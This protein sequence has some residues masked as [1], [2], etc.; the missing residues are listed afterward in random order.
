MTTGPGSGF[1]I[2]GAQAG[3]MSGHSVS[4]AG[5]VN[6]DGLADII[7]GSIYGVYSTRGAVGIAYIIFGRTAFSDIDLSTWA[8]GPTQGFRVVGAIVSEQFSVAVAGAGDINGD[9]FDDVIIGANYGSY[10]T[11]G[12]V[13]TACVVFGRA[14]PPALVDLATWAPTTSDGFRIFGVA[15]GDETGRALRAAGN[16]NGDGI[17]DV[18]LG[19][20]G[21]NPPGRTDAGTA[22]VIF[23]RATFPASIDLASW[24]TDTMN[25]FR[26]LGAAAG[27]GFGTHVSGAGDVNG[28]GTDDFIVGAHLFDS[29]GG[30]DAGAIYVIFGRVVAANAG[31]AFTEL[32]MSTFT[33]GATL[34]FRLLGA[35][36]SALSGWCVS[37]AGDVNG[38]GYSDI[39][40]GAFGFDAPGKV[41]AG[42]VYVIYGHNV[43]LPYQDIDLRYFVT[44]SVTG[45]R[46]VGAAAGDGLGYYVRSAGD[47]NNDGLADVMVSA[48]YADQPGQ[49]DAGT[50]YII[51]GVPNSPT[52]QP[53]S[54]PSRQP[55]RQPTRQPTGQPTRCP[56]RQPSSQPSAQPTDQPTS[57]PTRQPYGN[58]SSQ[59]SRQPT[60]CPTVQ[61]SAQPTARPSRQPSTQPTGIPTAQPS[62]Q[63]TSQPTIQPSSRPSK[64]PSSQPTV[65][66][67]SQPTA[68]PSVQPTAQPSH[69][70]TAEPSS[71]PT[72]TP[73][74]QPTSRPTP[75]PTAQPSAQPSA[76]PSVQP[77]SMPSCQPSSQ[78]SRQPSGE[79]TGQPTSTPTVQPSSQPTSCPSSVPSTQ[80]SN[81][82]SGQPSPEPSAQPSERPSSQP[83]AQPSSQPSRLPSAQP[84][85][86]P[87]A[88]PSGQPTVVP[89]VVPS[90]QPS[91]VP[92]TQP[93][94]IPSSQPSAQ[95]TLQP[96][97]Q[98]SAI[99][100]AAPS[101]QPMSCPTAQPSTQP[102][103]RPSAQPTS[104]PSRQPSAQPTSQ[105]TAAPSATNVEF[106][107]PVSRSKVASAFAL[108]AQMWVCS[109]A[110]DTTSAQCKTIATV[111]GAVEQ[112]Y[113]FPW[114]KTNYVFAQSASNSAYLSG[115]VRNSNITGGTS[116]SSAVAVC[117]AH[118]VHLSCTVKSFADTDIVAAS[119]NSF[120]QKAVYIGTYAS[121]PT[122]LVVDSTDAV[123]SFMYSA[124]Y[125]RAITLATV[126]HVPN[127]IGSFVAGPCVSNTAA[128]Q[129]MIF[130]GWLRSDTGTLSAAYVTTTSGMILNTAGLVN[131]M[132]VETNG[133]DS[134]IVGGLQLSDGVGMCGYMFRINTLFRDVKYGM[135]YTVTREGST[136]R[137]LL[138]SVEEASSTI[139]SVVWRDN[140]LFAVLQSTSVNTTSAA[141]L[142]LN[143]VTGAVVQQVSLYAPNASLICVSIQSTP[144]TVIITCNIYENDAHVRSVVIAADL[145]LTFSALPPGVHRGNDTYRAENVE[146]RATQ[147]SVT[148]APATLAVSNYQFDTSNQQPLPLSTAA[149]TSATPSARPSSQPTSRP[150]GQ[151]SSSPTSTPSMSP[152]PT[153]HPSTSGP[154]GTHKPSAVPTDSPTV[155]PTVVLTAV[156]S[157]KPSATPSR[158]PSITPTVLPTPLLTVRPSTSPTRTSSLRP[159]RVP[160]VRPSRV[161][162]TTHA[163]SVTSTEEV[164]IVDTRDNR[165]SVPS[166]VIGV[167]VGGVL[168]VAMCGYALFRYK[169]H[170]RE[171]KER[172]LR[173]VDFFA[174]QALLVA[175]MHTEHLKI[176][177]EE[178][179]RLA[180][181]ARRKAAQ[182]MRSGGGAHAVSPR[183]VV[184]TQAP[185]SPV[186]PV[187]SVSPLPPVRTVPPVPVHVSVDS[188]SSVEVSSLHS[189][190]VSSEVSSAMSSEQYSLSENESAYSKSNGGSNE[191][192]AECGGSQHRDSEC[193]D[194][195]GVEHDAI[196]SGEGS[197]INDQEDSYDN[198]NGD[199][200]SSWY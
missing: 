80:P 4:D 20:H 120:I 190:E 107:T 136:A 110:R 32:D 177:A 44:S 53:S 35:M 157:I 96:S 50:A 63:P 55:S 199:S 126:Q 73:S 153:S 192:A 36:G 117:A 147:V 18:I 65:Q 79:P 176:V 156:P 133:P 124:S 194:S 195:S 17:D 105:P 60:S 5:D 146:F 164:V 139:K 170:T 151:P 25:G 106:A 21:A 83:S 130:T 7:M 38:D 100:T 183:I 45:F 129:V 76:V 169:Q 189:S 141:V 186:P 41:D 142:K 150:S 182:A 172:A 98:P 102:T 29:Q 54:Q 19:A 198:V 103:I 67:T 86:Q 43:A 89:T 33:S 160:T 70:P 91:A 200:D 51:F 40:V 134:F 159:T 113:S 34:G 58:P 24:S 93:S 173:K 69:A 66:P 191:D 14:F 75:Q 1:R 10:S 125:L 158:L 121:R 57:Q 88:R 13:G 104:Q 168:L 118:S 180:D 59:P 39:V 8:P 61:P 131:G 77:S 15:S 108:G 161:H 166:Y 145:Q 196:M 114:D 2:I 112:A 174:Q 119:Y 95:P 167:A 62:Q 68:R 148:S 42:I 152:R 171:E 138:N 27:D 6:N 188:E 81:A 22:Y 78:P 97:V 46:I 127:F 52:S 184:P 165:E 181:K 135:R 16:V 92:S 185:I 90:T 132:A 99:P 175:Q 123:R 144:P 64:Q 179:Q 128:A 111:G 71:Q 11:R 178:E 82:P 74:T 31:N 154:T 162:T 163:P 137:R 197:G 193:G 85:R 143:A 109:D 30:V 49:L 87:S 84:S 9:G 72:G 47:M 94:S 23:G 140:R 56:T 155:V 122:F 187:S 12:N 3:E 28:D 101:T 26:M 37:G 115:S 116:V 149:P 48:P